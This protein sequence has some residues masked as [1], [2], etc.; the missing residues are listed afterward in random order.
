[1]NVDMRWYIALSAGFCA[2]RAGVSVG[3]IHESPSAEGVRR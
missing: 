1:M 3:A 2:G